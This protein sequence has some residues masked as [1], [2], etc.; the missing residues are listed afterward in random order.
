MVVF[1][2]LHYISYDMTKECIDNLI[3]TFKSDNYK[4]VL[5]DNGS[6]NGSGE[7][8]KADYNSHLKVDFVKIEKNC[9][10][11][12]G[13]NAGY[14]YAKEK[15]NPDFIIM[16]SNDVIINDL[17]F[18]DKI[19]KIYEETKFHVLGP[20]I[21]STKAKI[22]QSPLRTKPLSLEELE[23]YISNNEKTLKRFRIV[24]LKWRI[25]GLF[26][27]LLMKKKRVQ[28]SQ[29]YDLIQ[30]NVVL[31]GA[32]IIYS[33]DFISDEDYAFNP[34][35]YL[36]MEEDLL[37]NYCQ[38]K[39]YLVLYN[40]SISVNHMEDVDTNII[41][42]SNFTRTKNKISECLKSSYILLDEMKKG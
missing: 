30:K 39:G 40:P 27:R 6:P 42:K 41:Y 5:V 29:D 32:S 31:H 19:Y 11:A 36:Y 18:I 38:K 23:K 2:V 35:T 4:I 13:N 28:S 33:K 24:F 14:K 22:H 26:R 3:N 17:N 1:V 25:K 8:L 10:F 37:Y 16:V 9:G 12:N 15:Y 20:D 7:R 34:R 21:F